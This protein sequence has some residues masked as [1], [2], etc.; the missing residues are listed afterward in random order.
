MLTEINETLPFADGFLAKIVNGKVTGSTYE[1]LDG[2]SRY[3]HRWFL[4]DDETV[5]TGLNSL[6]G[7]YTA[8]HRKISFDVENSKVEIGKTLVDM[9]QGITSELF[10]TLDNTSLI[11]DGKQSISGKKFNVIS[12]INNSGIFN[13]INTDAY[14]LI[15]RQDYFGI[16]YHCEITS[17]D[18]Y[19]PVWTASSG[20]AESIPSMFTL[21]SSNVAPIENLG[22]VFRARTN[23]YLNISDGWSDFVD[24]KYGY[25]TIYDTFMIK[26]GL[27][28]VSNLSGMD[29]GATSH[30]C[31]LYLS[32]FIGKFFS[33][34]TFRMFEVG[35]DYDEREK[36][37]GRDSTYPNTMPLYNGVIIDHTG[38]IS[39]DTTG[40]I[41]GGLF[42]YR[43]DYLGYVYMFRESSIN[44][45]VF[46]F[47]RS[48]IATNTAVDWDKHYVDVGCTGNN[49]GVANTERV[50]KSYIG[51]GKGTIISGDEMFK[52]NNGGSTS[53]I[54][55]SK[56]V[57][58]TNIS[59]HNIKHDDQGRPDA[60]SFWDK[61][62]TGN[63]TVQ[64]I[65][66]FNAGG[67]PANGTIEIG[68]CAAL[69]M[70]TYSGW[71]GSTYSSKSVGYIGINIY[72]YAILSSG[73]SDSVANDSAFVASRGWVRESATMATMPHDNLGSISVIGL[74]TNLSGTTDTKKYHL[75]SR[76]MDRLYGVSRKSSTVVTT[77]NRN[78][79]VVIHSYAGGA[80]EIN[81]EREG[82]MIASW[83]GG[84][85]SL[86]TDFFDVTSVIKGIVACR[87]S[88]TSSTT[89][90]V[91]LGTK[92]TTGYRPI[93]KIH[94]I[95][96][97][98]AASAA[99]TAT[100][101]IT[102]DSSVAAGE[103]YQI[104]VYN[105]APYTLTISRTISSGSISNVS[106]IPDAGTPIPQYQRCVVSI[107]II[108]NDN[109][110]SGLIAACAVTIVR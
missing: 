13:A 89:I 35:V 39:V 101:S 40:V 4:N 68:V 94:E 53:Y 1:H 31:D 58:I 103:S 97:S 109:T 14:E 110:G 79:G 18:E 46:A 91:V 42:S 28:I 78:D 9:M 56:R 84:D 63:G 92:L 85:L 64:H 90:P 74:D 82:Q 43:T 61:S 37:G 36:S 87:K 25:D 105:N 21:D 22:G 11:W 107:T 73:H 29:T 65:P 6:V 12:M 19:G 48:A 55:N 95:R 93:E 41:G 52:Y 76:E 88:N 106:N 23:R 98:A 96:C 75:G 27:E 49:Y 51:I 24:P 2:V 80:R 8:S 38:G 7:M 20:F 57:I 50:S 104:F 47:S 59:S 17:F 66:F 77:H 10:V 5:L 26:R 81:P 16:N 83:D 99:A 102:F 100:L 45:P 108:D 71:T 34:G 69:G 67:D 62:K 32:P 54:N 30:K 33:F 3:F 60:F 72:G 44:T 86:R 70:I 15:V